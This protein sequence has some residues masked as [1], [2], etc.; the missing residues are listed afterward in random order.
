M[1]VAPQ[2]GKLPVRTKL[3][4]ST[5]DLTSSLTLAIQTFFQLYFL[6]D[7]AR[8]N[9]STVGW[10]LGITRLWDAVNDPLIGLFSDRISSRFGR[11]G[12]RSRTGPW[13]MPAAKG[14][15]SRRSK[16]LCSRAKPISRS[17]R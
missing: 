3:L 2:D 9:P 5:G 1:N 11:R 13:P 8:L 6:T 4:F 17:I 16:R 14:C 12:I 7:V 15:S 10:I